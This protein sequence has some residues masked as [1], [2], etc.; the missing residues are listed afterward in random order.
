VTGRDDAAAGRAVRVAILDAQPGHLE[1][2]ARRVVLKA[3]VEL[4]L[5]LRSGDPRRFGERAQALRD[6]HPDVVLVPVADRGGADELVLLAEP[7]RFGCAAQRPVPRVLL[8]CGDDGAIARASPL[9]AAF[10]VDLLPD[11]R[12]DTGRARAVARLRELR[13]EGARRDDALEEL[14]ARAAQAHGAPVLV[15][16]VGGSSTSLVRADAAGALLAAHVRPL[17]TGTAADRVIARAGL[18]RVRRW[19]PWA[20]DQPTLLERVFNR[21]RWPGAVSRDREA[22]AVEIALA[23]EAIAHAASDANAAGIGASLR[24]APRLLLTGR[25]AELA[26]PQAA[27]IAAD[28]ID[29]AGAA[30]ISRDEDGALMRAAAEAIASADHAALDA[31]I[32]EAVA[33]IAAVVPVSTARRTVVRITSAGV[34]REERVDRDAFYALAAEGELELSGGGVEEARVNGGSIGLIVD[35]RPRPL[36]LPL[37][38]AERVPAVA[39]WYEALGALPGSAVATGSVAT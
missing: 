8:A 27:L 26:A 37:R 30:S 19:I 12:A 13:G 5:A 4:V 11:I 25:L 39:R 34:R 2:A 29:L 20:V 3:G 14:A 16:D 9:L 7:L 22:L 6:A 35:A 31:A 21:A 23:H 38:D 33:P 17:G 24:A 32:A 1:Q 36:V 15:V 28:A 10:P 18:D